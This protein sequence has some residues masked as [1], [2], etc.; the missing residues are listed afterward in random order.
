MSQN[1]PF[2]T[3]RETFFRSVLPLFR[4][5]HVCP[6]YADARRLFDHISACLTTHPEWI[7]NEFGHNRIL[8]S[9]EAIK[10]AVEQ[11]GLRGKTLFSYLLRVVTPT[12]EATDAVEN[13]FGK[14]TAEPI[15][16]FLRLQAIE[17][18]PEAMKTE[19]YRNLLV[20]QVRDMRV[21]LLLIAESVALM[22]RIKDTEN[23]KAQRITSN[24][25]AFIYA[26][27]AHKLGLYQLK[28]ELEDLS[29]KYLEPE[30]YYMIKD[31]LNATKR[32]RDAY[33]ER[34]TQPIQQMLDK[35]GLR[36]HIKGRTKSIHSIWQKMKRQKC[37]FEGV[38]DL[39]AIRIIIDAPEKKEEEQCWKAF[40]LITN[41]YTGDLKRLRDWLTVPKSNGYESLHITVLGPEDKWVEVQI[42][43]ERMD[44]IAEHGLAAHWRY[45][46]VKSSGGTIESWLAD[47]RSALETSDESLLQGSLTVDST[48][49]E[50]YVFS[51]KETFTDCR[52][53]R[54]YSTLPI[55]FIRALATVV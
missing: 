33:I 37:D 38:Y 14:E 18:K 52:L 23:V 50:V 45:K 6:D 21:V 3:A 29:L 30:A 11:I 31:H 7:Y 41:R 16:D 22:R 47:I 10:I 46:G 34:F 44:E 53:D 54:P 39:F 51:P 25:A 2:P 1:E 55:P 17:A 13:I 42:R 24:E 19:N 5:P 26:P 20:S 36:Y 12:K 49:R 32:S 4:D 40:S 8:L 27:L 15:R 35:E 9:L 28:S 48:N 43:T